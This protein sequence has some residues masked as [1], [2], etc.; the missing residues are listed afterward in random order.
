MG[1][2]KTT[3]PTASMMAL[4]RAVSSVRAS[5]VL[6]TRSSAVEVLSLGG[7]AEH[8]GSVA[9]CSDSRPRLRPDD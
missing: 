4:V 8:S 7:V 3:L 1:I 6:E 5:I 9:D 2:G